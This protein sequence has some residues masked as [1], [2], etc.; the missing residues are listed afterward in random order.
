MRIDR[1]LAITVMLLNRKR[2]SAR[3]LA[4][5][6]E[7]SIRTVYRDIDAI[8][9]A[10][11]PI[12]SY[13]GNNGGFGIIDT[14]KIDRQL[15]SLN[16]MLSM[17]SALKGVNTTLENNELDSAIEKIHSLVPKDK[18]EQL[19]LHLEQ[20]IIDLFPWGYSK[21]KKEQL[22]IVHKAISAEKLI[23]FD[24]HNQK[25]EHVNRTVEPMTIL[26]KGF[27]WYLF[28]YCTVR[29]DFRIFRLTRLKNITTLNKNFTRRKKSY[30]DMNPSDNI[31]PTNLMKLVLKFSSKIRFRV[32]DFYEEENIEYLESGEM[33]VTVK[34]PE[35]EWVYSTILSYGEH[36]E[37][38]EP[39]HVRKIIQQKAKKI[40]QLSQT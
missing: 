38:L 18:K 14:Y 40:L 24:Y 30:N 36:V 8:N 32:E 27:A 15:L 22:Q 26:L 23:N 4:E 6:F 20:F 28:G 39:L 34:F 25:G 35:D 7:I 19:N 16:D 12:V 5:K 21:K 11:I 37:V 29:N 33:L 13:A 2:I 17:L 9:M 10:G 1:M 3:E 31:Q